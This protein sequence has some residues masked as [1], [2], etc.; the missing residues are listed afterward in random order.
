W[1]GFQ[2]TSVQPLWQGGARIWWFRRFLLLS[3]KDCLK[4][5]SRQLPKYS[6]SAGDLVIRPVFL[7]RASLHVSLLEIFPTFSKI[8]MPW[9]AG[10]RWVHPTGMVMPV[11]NIF[12]AGWRRKFWFMRGFFFGRPAILQLGR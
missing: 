3:Q 8:D 10:V 12:T 4:R 11:V 5:G 6:G 2:L 7:R 9:A 1:A